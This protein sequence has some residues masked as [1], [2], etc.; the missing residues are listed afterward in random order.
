[1]HRV[2]AVCRLVQFKRSRSTIVEEV[3]RHPHVA[4]SVGGCKTTVEVGKKV[5]GG[6]IVLACGKD[7]WDRDTDIRFSV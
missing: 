5:D 3:D 1:L 4:A 7:T 6:A 2:G